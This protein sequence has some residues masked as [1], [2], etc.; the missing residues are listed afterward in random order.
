[1]NE[2]AQRITE[3]LKLRDVMEFYGVQ[4]N[5]RGF[6]RCPFHAEKTASLSIKNEHYKCFGCG[7]YGGVIDFVMNYYG[8]K[9]MQAVVKLDS[10]FHLGIVGGRR[11]TYRENVERAA[12]ARIDKAY[13]EWQDELHRNYLTVCIMRRALYGMY[14]NG[15]EQYG[16]MVDRFDMLLDDFT[17]EEARAWQMAIIP[18]S[19]QKSTF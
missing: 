1:M 17:G 9:F 16:E 13:K 3:T 7:A 11:P 8:L 5:S 4:F 2:L 15:E 14:I 18:P 12:E 10:D 6:A 19:T